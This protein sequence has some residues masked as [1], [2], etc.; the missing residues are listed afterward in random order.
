MG[1]K[2]VLDVVQTILNYTEKLLCI[3]SGFSVWS[4]TGL[5]SGKQNT[6]GIYA[7]GVGLSYGLPRV[8]PLDASVN[9]PVTVLL[10]YS[11]LR[12]IGL[13]RLLKNKLT[14]PKSIMWSMMLPISIRM[15]VY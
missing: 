7:S 4:V 11:V 6:L 3:N 13:S 8:I 15:G 9:S 10:S 5:L 12:T 14:T 2:D 1:K